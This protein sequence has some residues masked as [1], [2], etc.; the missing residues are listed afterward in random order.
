M[1]DDWVVLAPCRVIGD[2]AEI[3]RLFFS[4]APANIEEARERFCRKCPFRMECFAMQNDVEEGLGAEH[5]YGLFGGVTGAQRAS[6]AARGYDGKA[7]PLLLVEGWDS[8][9]Q[10]EVPPM[11][12]DGDRWSRHHTQIA[13]K[14]V[15]WLREESG[16]QPG[17]TL[18]R[19]KEVAAAV[20]VSA[21]AMGRVLEAL[22]ADGT[23]DVVGLTRRQHCNG[24]TRSYTLRSLPG[25]VS[26]WLP[27]H[28]LD[29]G[30]S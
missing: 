28:L 12:N 5:R 16:L 14:V 29:R 15:R 18:P 7:D 2:G 23:L 9:A 4:M 11:D 24:A 10:R 8:D 3:D 20:R 30:E 21:S 13:R 27:S 1:S 6:L 26:S 17:D 25:A 22:V 19:N